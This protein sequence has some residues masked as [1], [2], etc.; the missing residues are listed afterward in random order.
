MAD[1]VTTLLPGGLSN[2]AI[3]SAL[4]TFTA[5]DPS[6]NYVFFDDFSKFVADDW[7]A[8]STG[9]A[10]YAAGDAANG[11]LL[12]TNSAANNDLAALQ[13]DNETFG[14][15]PKKRSWMKVRLKVNNASLAQMAVG[16]QIRDTTPLAVSDGVFFGKAG[17]TTNLT[18]TVVKNSVASTV[19]LANAL[20]DDTFV[21]IGFAY[22]P[23]EGAFSVYLNDNLLARCPSTNFPDDELLAVSIAL[24]NGSAQARVMSVDYFMA[25]QER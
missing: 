3:G 14:L 22:D 17:G 20:A 15:D 11:I 7:T 4:S 2:A 1:N 23:N 25:A 19:V 9:A 8:T 16:L 5:E 21:E 10:T 6:K 18:F 24:A 13:W 12:I